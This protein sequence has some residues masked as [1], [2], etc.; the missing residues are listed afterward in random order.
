MS[1]SKWGE[2]RI[3]V[4]ITVNYRKK[5]YVKPTHWGGLDEKRM[6]PSVHFSTHLLCARDSAKEKQATATQLVLLP[7]DWTLLIRLE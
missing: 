4:K 2:R 1:T 5:N 3:T 6:T 7:R